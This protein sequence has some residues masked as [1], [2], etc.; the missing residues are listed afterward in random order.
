[1]SKKYDLIVVGG[2][3]AGIM[4]AKTAAEKGL[5]VA[6]LLARKKDPLCI[7]RPCAE[8]LVLNEEMYGECTCFN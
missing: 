5:G 3:P 4:A 6:L 8:T 2:G 1:M 7:S